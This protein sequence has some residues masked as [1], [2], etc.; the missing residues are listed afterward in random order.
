MWSL[1]RSKSDLPSPLKK[2]L[3]IIESLKF[4]KYEFEEIFLFPKILIGILLFPGL[5]Q[6]QYSLLMFLL[7][8]FFYYLSDWWGGRSPLPSL[9][10]LLWASY[11]DLKYLQWHVISALSNWR[12]LFVFDIVITSMNLAFLSLNYLVR[13]STAKNKNV[14]IGRHRQKYLKSSTLCISMFS[15]SVD[16]VIISYWVWISFKT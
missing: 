13:L 10:D 3:L 15:F 9:S 6:Y 4:L 7:I 8:S 11:L 16:T 14:P 2:T 1:K 12:H 5:K